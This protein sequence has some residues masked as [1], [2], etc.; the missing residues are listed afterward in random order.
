MA[1]KKATKKVVRKAAVKKLVKKDKKEIVRKTAVRAVQSKKI[2]VKTLVKHQPLKSTRE[3]FGEALVELG[4]SNKN[5]VVL[6]GDLT[7]SVK[8]EE[9][10]QQ[11]PERFFQCGVA[12]ANMVGMAAGLALEGKIPFVTSFGSFVPNRCLDHIRQ[13]VCYNQANAKVASTHCGLI[14]G[15]DGATH[16]PLEDIAIMRALPGM[17][18]LVPAD[19]NEAKKAT[20]AA[21]RVHGP[22]YIRLAR[23]GTEMITLERS[24]FKLGKLSVLREGK[25]LAIIGC[26]PI[27][28]QAM[29]AAKELEKRKIKVKVINC[30]TLK[31]IDAEG[32]VAVARETGAVLTVED[33]QVYGGL[34]G[35]VAEVLGQSKVAV[36]LE[37]LGIRNAFG[38]SGKPWELLKKHGLDSLSIAAAAEK[39]LK[40]K[41][42]LLS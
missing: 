39:L 22:V 26:G 23:P 33:H 18:V 32:L 1:K 10:A 34:G 36:P 4:K 12:E 16:Q 7:E 2:S 42:E 21:A 24:E 29:R 25:D 17:T 15:E 41:G 40:R 37:I 19:F 11:H 35:A 13:S 30:H 28:E 5:V 3:G 8:A 27:L 38:E 20:L 9:F 6:C 31:P 14:T